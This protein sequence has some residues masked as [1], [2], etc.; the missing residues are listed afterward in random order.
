MSCDAH[1]T[2]E[3]NNIFD[4]HHPLK[5]THMYVHTVHIISVTAVNCKIDLMY[6]QI[7]FCPD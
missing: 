5:G 4:T 3:P 1:H 7:L 2:A 6:Q